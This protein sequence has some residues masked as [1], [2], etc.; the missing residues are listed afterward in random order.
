MKEI[1]SS[2][3]T[4]V[5]FIG[6]TLLS[7]E[8]SDCIGKNI[9]GL[10][11][12]FIVPIRRGRIVTHFSCINCGARCGPIGINGVNDVQLFHSTCAL[13]GI[14]IGT[15]GPLF[16]HGRSGAMFGIDRLGGVKTVGTASILGCTPGIVIRSSTS[17]KIGVGIGGART[18]VFMGS[19][20]L[21]KA[22]L[23]SFLSDVGTSSVRDVRVRSARN[24][25]RSTSVGNNVIRVEAEVQTNFGKD[26]AKCIKGLDPRSDGF[27]SCCPLLG[28]GLKARH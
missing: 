15:C 8:S 13:G 22:R 20:G 1:L 10:S 2:G 21:T 4:P 6:V 12:S 9:D 3:N 26:V 11:N 7:I 18:A 17:K 14:I 23:G 28:F 16:R 5:R 19:E 25:R 27:C 24:T